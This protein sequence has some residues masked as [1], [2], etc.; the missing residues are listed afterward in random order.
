MLV[1]QT[2]EEVPRIWAIDVGPDAPTVT[3]TLSVI[4]TSRLVAVHFRCPLTALGLPPGEITLKPSPEPEIPLPAAIGL[5]SLVI[6]G[7]EATEWT[8]IL[9][10]P[11]NALTAL[12][13]LPSEPRVWDCIGRTISIDIGSVSAPRPRGRATFALALKS[14]RILV[15][16]D[17]ALAFTIDTVGTFRE[18]TLA[19]GGPWL[20][21]YQGPDERIWLLDE[22]GR[23]A[24]GRLDGP[25]TI[26]TS[27]VPVSRSVLSA[28][29]A[30]PRDD[31]TPFELY[32]AAE[33]R[34]LAR[35][36]GQTWTDLTANP[37]SEVPDSA[38]ALALPDLHWLGPGRVLASGVTRRLG[39]V[40]WIEA[41]TSTR[42]QRVL[43]GG[44]IF[45]EFRETASG[46]LLGG[47]L[48]GE[49]RL[50]DG[51]QWPVIEANGE[52]YAAPIIPFE[53][54]FLVGGIDGLTLGRFQWFQLTEAGGLC[55][56]G[57]LR[58]P[59]AIALW[60]IGP[61][62]WL[63]LAASSIETREDFGVIRI[64]GHPATREVCAGGAFPL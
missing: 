61:L 51:T 16:T 15:G 64:I 12:R 49:L 43:S 32:A 6:D 56:V 23:L 50:F 10:L 36:D 58:L 33:D 20:A 57:T 9:E 38:L 28:A 26:A 2:D 62:Q 11:P 39:T 59:A 44:D 3:P 55:P 8:P 30:G 54:T 7:G 46:T 4:G 29:L 1:V 63:H 19:P 5:Q 45:V 37:R 35:F 18:V 34:T 25:W 21:A 60:S 40:V 48:F 41:Q 14:D 52:G 53:D 13:R 24:S 27:S 47:T 31:Q 17:R 22:D 42:T